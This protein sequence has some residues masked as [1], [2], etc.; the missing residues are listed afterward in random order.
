MLFYR[1]ELYLYM[2]LAPMRLGFCA[3]SRDREG[4]RIDVAD[5]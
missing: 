4:K 2:I 5:K 1:K 3:L